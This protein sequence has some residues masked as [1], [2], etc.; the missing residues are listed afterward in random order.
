MGK[1]PIKVLFLAAEAAPIAKAGGLADVVGSLPKALQG[2]GVDVRIALPLYH[3]IDRKQFSIRRRPGRFSV[4]FDGIRHVV[5][6]FTTTLPH[7]SVPVYLLDHPHYEGAGDIYYQDVTN[8]REQ[9]QLQVERFLFFSLAARSLPSFLSW[10]PDLVHCHDWHTAAFP[11]F[12]AHAEEVRLRRL[13]TVYT[14]H[15]LPLQ[16]SIG[17]ARFKGLV[18]NALAARFPQG[19]VRKEVI[20]LTALGLQTANA[21]TTVSPSYAKEILT[22][23]QGAGLMQILR[24]RRSVLTGI[25]N[26]LDVDA[27]D[28]AT[29]TAIHRFS[30]ATIAEKEKNTRTLLRTT[31]LELRRPVFGM[32]SRLTSQKGVE[33]V[34]AILPRLVELGCSAVVLGSGEP[35]LERRLRD[36]AAHYPRSVAVRIGFDARFAQII[37]AGSDVFLMP[38]Q[39][40]PC[41]LGQMI[42][43]RY[44]AVPVVRA[45][46][47]LKDTV[48]EGK[49]GN[50]FIFT[51]YA[52]KDFWGA[53]RRAL[54]LYGDPERWRALQLR[55]MRQNL[56]WTSSA[57]A[58]R[59]I[60]QQALHAS[61]KRNP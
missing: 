43:L 7:S 61:K 56:S 18:G 42:A 28:P 22:P 6:V 39:F 8:S 5:R 40:E 51:R 55:G 38:S 52:V 3:K 37:Y 21:I 1:P 9:Q 32:V 57:R 27:Y 34:C 14:I 25:L 16:G 29:D 13:A 59:N 60:Y 44:G 47:G 12:A 54:R 11:L 33:L 49:D 17:R 41:G 15:N 20:N 45:T 58:Y 26:G 19:V 24:S 10:W 4:V 23:K 35:A 2:L 36:I 30:A 46:G 50:G 53:C 31:G 48:R